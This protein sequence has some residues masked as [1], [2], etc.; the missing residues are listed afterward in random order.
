MCQKTGVSRRVVL[1]CVSRDALIHISRLA[2]EFVSDP[3]EIVGDVVQV[4]V[5][6]VDIP[7]KRISLTRKF[8][9]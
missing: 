8:K 6:N 9:A 3:N 5:L 7:R 4:E 1:W 2:D